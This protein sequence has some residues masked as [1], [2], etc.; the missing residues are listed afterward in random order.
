MKTM[1]FIKIS[2]SYNSKHGGEIFYLFFKDEDGKS[3]RTVLYDNMRN[4]SNWVDII[5]NAE[6]GDEI[7]NLRTILY[8][9][10]PIV[11]ADSR[12]TNITKIADKII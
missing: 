6:R 4:F 3:F 10:K 9:G 5:N 7:G 11:D 2:K 8:K 12:P 1:K